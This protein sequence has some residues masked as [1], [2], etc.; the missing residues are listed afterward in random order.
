MY[1]ST[2][3]KTNIVELHAFPF[4]VKL[5][6]TPEEMEGLYRLRYQAFAMETNNEQLMNDAGMEQDSFDH[7][8][9]HLIVKDQLSGEVVGTYRLLPGSRVTFSKGF[10]SQSEFDFTFA[11]WDIHRVLELGRSCVAPAYRNGRVI[12]LLWEGIA[13]YLSVY[14]HDHLIGCASMEVPNVHDLD[15][16]I[17]WMKQKKTINNRYGIQPLTKNRIHRLTEVPVLFSD[18]EMFRKLPPL[19]KGYLSLGAQIATEP[20]YDPIF[21]TI[22]FLIVMPVDALNSR[23]MRRFAIP[24]EK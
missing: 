19:L 15:T 1:A 7:W 14:P 22:D 21:D 3:E 18:R 23:F 8:C 10:Y 17:T 9:D 24:V 6:T 5:A 2:V 16:I 12:Q 4:L 11:T 13:L 20:A